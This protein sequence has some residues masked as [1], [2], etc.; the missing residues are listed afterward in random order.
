MKV[1]IT[2]PPMLKQIEEFRPLFIE[3]GIELVVPNVV[4]TLTEDELVE[5]VPQVDGWIIGDDPA[6]YKVFYAGKKG[7]F[8][9]AVKWGVGTDN[10]DFK[11]C[12]QL[13][14][15]VDNTPMMF[16]REVATLTVHYLIGLAR[17]TFH[18]DREVRKGNW[19]K[20]TGISLMG[21]NAAIIGF[22]DIGKHTAQLL[23]SFGMEIMVYDPF[24]KPMAEEK[25][26]CTFLTW[27]E[28]IEQA[29]FIIVTCAL[30]QSTYHLLDSDAIG[31]MKQ[32][33][34]IINVSRGPVIDEQALIDG[35]RSGKVGGAALD[36]YE[37]EPLPMDSPLRTFDNCIL[38]THNA[39]NTIEAVRRASHEAIK[40]LFKMLEVN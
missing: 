5:I 19:V 29:D 9:A 25:A 32:G 36:V 14:I 3:K 8:K 20:P 22:G 35:M 6:T 18:I 31:R 30:N 37:Q 26:M 23:H 24:V 38:G 4:Q 33:V 39:S 15:P 34:R 10:V 17:H 21:K 16:G 12:E 11:A 40:K 27:P 28:Q 13:G 7:R 2:C 1:L